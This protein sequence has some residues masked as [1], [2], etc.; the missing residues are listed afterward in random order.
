MVSIN[1][2]L[3]PQQVLQ[4]YYKLYPLQATV[5][6]GYT[7]LDIWRSQRAKHRGIRD[8]HIRYLDNDPSQIYLMVI[9]VDELD[10]V[11]R[12]PIMRLITNTSIRHVLQEPFANCPLWLPVRSSFGLHNNNNSYSNSDVVY[13]HGANMTG[14]TNMMM[15]TTATAMNTPYQIIPC[16]EQWVESVDF[17]VP[18]SGEEKQIPAVVDRLIQEVRQRNMLLRANAKEMERKDLEIVRLRDLNRVHHDGHHQV[19]EEKGLVASV[20]EMARQQVADLDPEV[21]VQYWWAV[22]VMVV[23]LGIILF[24]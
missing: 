13:T 24:R 3:L 21:W 6:P 20:A 18:I 16:Y 9:F 15:T 2:G 4:H 12:Q 8:I 17:E 10:P 22:A 14:T 19:V 11:M 23:L 1:A 5:H 7:E